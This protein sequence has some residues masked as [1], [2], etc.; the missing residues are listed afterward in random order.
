VQRSRPPCTLTHVLC[1]PTG[2]QAAQLAVGRM[3]AAVRDAREDAR[4]A[5]ACA[6]AARRQLEQAEQRGEQLSRQLRAAAGPQVMAALAELEHTA[7][8]RMCAVHLV[9]ANSVHGG[10][11]RGNPRGLEGAR[12]VPRRS[13]WTTP[14]SAPAYRNRHR[15]RT[16]PGWCVRVCACVR[17]CVRSGGE[18]DGGGGDGG[19]GCQRRRD[20]RAHGAGGAAA[21]VQQRCGPAL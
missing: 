11:C 4:E 15:H 20:A 16:D 17:V 3:E 10:R 5:A 9:A 6:E 1:V 19:G 2:G 21:L 7:G 8:A 12:E 18:G 14:D 13:S